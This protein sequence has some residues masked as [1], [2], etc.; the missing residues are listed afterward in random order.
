MGLYVCAEEYPS[1]SLYVRAQEYPS[2]SLYV[3][4]EEYPS[5]GLLCARQRVSI[6]PHLQIGPRV[7][8]TSL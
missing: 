2:M 5:L 4:A 8:I 1:M 6:N 3:R 7:L